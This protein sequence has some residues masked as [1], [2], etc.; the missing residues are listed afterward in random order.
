MSMMAVDTETTGLDIFHGCRPFLVT[1]C[2]GN[3]NYV[4][5]GYVNRQT[6]NVDWSYG[7][8]R[9]IQ[10]KLDNTKTIIFHNTNFDRRAL[11]SIG[12]KTAHLVP[13]IEDTLIASHV[14]CSGDVHGLK[15]LAIKYLRYHDHD[16]QYLRQAITSRRAD[17]AQSDVAIA[18]EGHPHFPAIKGKSGTTWWAMDMWL[19]MDACI[20]YATRDVE[21]TYLLWL[22]FIRGL[23]DQDLVKVYKRRMNL[24]PVLYDMQTHGIP[25]YVNKCQRLIK[26]L[27][28]QKQGL[29]NLIMEAAN[30]KGHL[31][32]ESPIHMQKLLFSP[33][34]L[35]L[36]PVNDTSSSTPEN[37]KHATDKETLKTLFEENP[38]VKA[39]KYLQAWREVSTE[40]SYVQ[41]YIDWSSIHVDKNPNSGKKTITYRLHS[42]LNATGTKWTRQSSSDPNQQ[43]FKKELK[44]LFGPPEGYYWLYMDVVNIEL[45][46]WAYEVGSVQLIKAFEA[47]ESVHMIIARTIRQHQIDIAGGESAWKNTDPIHKQYTKTKGGTFAWIYGGSTRKVNQTYGIPNAQ[48]MIKDKLPE[49]GKYFEQLNKT[50]SDNVAKYGYPTIFTRAGYK[51]EVPRTKPHKVPSARIQGSAGEIVQDM[52]V[53][54]VKHP[55]YIEK[56]CALMQQVHDSITIQIPM[57]SGSEQTNQALIQEVERVGRLHIPTCPMDGEVILPS[58]DEPI[59]VKIHT[60]LP[61]TYKDFTIEYFF[62]D[63]IGWIARAKYESLIITGTGKTQQEA[64]Q[65][66]LQKI[67]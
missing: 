12:I 32:L 63:N 49:V 30:W 57:H 44:Y 20:T 16:E 2:D 9:E 13:R 50:M 39:L 8:L 15:D 59:Q 31:N 58:P 34:H 51:L 5:S 22:T 7:E 40:L 45:R 21:R 6:R 24:L 17:L 61:E 37:P 28:F 38:E 26:H 66:L 52:M 67:G 23:L 19:D 11:E 36:E 65:T 33:Q 25:I 60:I 55:V 35:G 14:L 10:Y 27:E 62:Q 53:N 56:L 4:W 1:A 3:I 42:A 46:I 54:L 43:N 41:S 64:Y 29:T 47:N 18:R 48:E